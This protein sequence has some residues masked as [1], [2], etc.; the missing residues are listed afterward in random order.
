MG[1]SEH[2]AYLENILTYF[3]FS[4]FCDILRPFAFSALGR[5]RRG[6]YNWW[7]LAYC[8]LNSSSCASCQTGSRLFH[9]AKTY[10]IVWLGNVAWHGMASSHTVSNCEVCT[11]V[12]VQER[13]VSVRKPSL[14]LPE[15]LQTTYLRQVL[16]HVN[17][18][19]M[20]RQ[21]RTTWIMILRR[22]W[23]AIK[24]N[25]TYHVHSHGHGLELS[26]KSAARNPMPGV[27]ERWSCV[28]RR[29]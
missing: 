9:L 10:C 11:P 24:I 1:L 4:C 17:V 27:K 8:Q 5:V 13:L 26:S 14:C 15:T 29:D 21:G 22:G 18:M 16:T 23:K 2:A 20:I 6:A 19:T 12:V 7:Q 28:W 25:Q 3:E